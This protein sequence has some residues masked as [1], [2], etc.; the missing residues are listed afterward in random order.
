MTH[1]QEKRARTLIA[2]KMFVAPDNRASHHEAVES[3]EAIRKRVD[4]M[5]IVELIPALMGFSYDFT[6]IGTIMTRKRQRN[7]VPKRKRAA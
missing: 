4:T 7:Y 3:Y 5:E 2:R 6:P 1:K